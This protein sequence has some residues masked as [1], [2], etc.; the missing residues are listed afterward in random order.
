MPTKNIQMERERRLVR[1]TTTKKKKKKAKAKR[2]K[3]CRQ[4]RKLT[5]MRSA[6]ENGSDR[7]QMGW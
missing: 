1:M 6:D 4:A 7:E 2:W 5:P 3:I